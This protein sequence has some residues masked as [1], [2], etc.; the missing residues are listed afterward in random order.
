MKTLPLVSG[1]ALLVGLGAA[2]PSGGA[3]EVK[4]ATSTKGAVAPIRSGTGTPVCIDSL[5]DQ[6]GGACLEAASAPTFGKLYPLGP[7]FNIDP[8]GRV[9]VGTLAPQRALDV[10][11]MVRSR[12]G[13]I[14]YPDG[15]IQST[16]TLTGPQG[17]PGPLTPPEPTTT[18]GSIQFAGFGCAPTGMPL[19][20]FTHA[21]SNPGG[22]SSL[23][24]LSFAKDV[25]ACS[26]LILG[27]AV[28]GT[29][30]P[31]AIVTVGTLRIT[32]HD[33]RVTSVEM[34]SIENEHPREK[35]VL[36]VES[37]RWDE[38]VAGTS[39]DWDLLTSTGSGSPS[40]AGSS[41]RFVNVDTG[42]VPS[43]DYPFD[44]ATQTTSHPLG[45]PSFTSNLILERSYDDLTPSLLHA[46]AAGVILTQVEAVEMR[47][48]TILGIDTEY[49]RYDLTDARVTEVRLERKPTG[50]FVEVVSLDFTSMLWSFDQD[51]VIT[52]VP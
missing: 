36:E 48:S 22:G 47:F 15:T 4:Q 11:G 19:Y 46:C 33:V 38:T 31:S 6:S 12:F 23:V 25:D 39:G 49:L 14:E 43:G 34:L 2:G 50:E 1:I 10:D 35:V 45:S 29:V 21:V 30:Y 8:L 17:P 32:L 13:G 52:K 40:L 44:F 27:A 28:S 5:V 18:I 16:A 26:F 3:Q 42:S 41:L 9:G 37:L 20:S 7:E 51:G 24:S